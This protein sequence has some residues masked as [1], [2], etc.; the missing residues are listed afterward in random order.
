M[1]LSLVEEAVQ[2]T[3]MERQAEGEYSGE[4]VVVKAYPTETGWK[5]MADVYGGS[6]AMR[7]YETREEAYTVFNSLVDKHGIERGDE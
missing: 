6:N 5:L 1:S 2:D 4:T 7:S 3:Q